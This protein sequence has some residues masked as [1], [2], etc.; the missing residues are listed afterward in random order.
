[1]TGWLITNGFL[2]TK[3]FQ[4]LTDLFMLSASTH[5]IK[6]KEIPNT[7]LLP[8]TPVRT[9]PDFVIFWDK[10]IL[11]AR[12]LEDLNIPVFNSSQFIR[13]VMTNEKPSLR[14]PKKGFL[15]LKPFWPL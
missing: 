6:L 1:M 10:D 2:R 9:K 12:Y 5:G 13:I 15:F 3:K 4:E 8:G 14:S 7:K 11:L